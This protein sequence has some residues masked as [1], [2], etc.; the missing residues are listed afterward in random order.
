MQMDV[1]HRALTSFLMHSITVEV[2]LVF[3][4]SIALLKVSEKN[5]LNVTAKMLTNTDSL[6]R[7]LNYD[8]GY[9]FLRAIR[10]TPLYWMSTQK[11]PFALIRELGIPTFFA[12]ADLRWPE[13]LNSIIKQEG[14]QTNKWS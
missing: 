6:Q 5:V 9:K 8:E 7:I 10:G 12:S 4:V 3:N 11:Y 14:K 1:L 13:I 2:D